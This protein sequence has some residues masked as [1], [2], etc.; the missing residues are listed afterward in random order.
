MIFKCAVGCY[1]HQIGSKGSRV[2]PRA[3]LVKI[4]GYKQEGLG[5]EKPSTN[6]TLPGQLHEKCRSSF[7]CGYV[8]REICQLADR[9]K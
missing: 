7:K 6:T 3:S 5:R 1:S 9:V 8:N 2:H 4:S